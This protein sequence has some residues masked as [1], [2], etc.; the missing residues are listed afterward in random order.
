M[1]VA[2]IS[3]GAALAGIALGTLLYAKK[4]LKSDPLKESLG[5]FYQFVVR[6]YYLDEFFVWLAGIFQNALARVFLWFDTNIVIQKGVNGTASLTA[7][8]GSLL[9]RAQ[10]G[11]VQSYAMVFA[12]G[13]VS[14]I[15]FILM[16]S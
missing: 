7:D 9:R 14:I 1:M 2:A 8:F 10:T 12:V 5:A 3:V 13:I 15:Y 6:K 16:R 11:V 4:S